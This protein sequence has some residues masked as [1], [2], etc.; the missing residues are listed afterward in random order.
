[1]S[2]TFKRGIR[3]RRLA[4]ESLEDRRLLVTVVNLDLGRGA[5]PLHI[6]SSYDDS[7]PLPL[8]VSLHGYSQSGS[9]IANYLNLSEQIEDN[10]FLYLVPQGNVDPGGQYFWN[11]TDA[12]CN[13][14]GSNVA[15]STYLR[16][17]VE[18]VSRTYAVDDRSIHFMG[19]SNGGFMTHRMALE[20]ADMV[21][22]IISLS[23]V[24]YLDT[25]VF[26]PSEPVH[27]LHVHGTADSVIRYA[28]GCIGSNCY[29]SAEQ[30]VLDWTAYNGL[31]STREQVGGPFDL[32]VDVNG[33]EATKY[34]YDQGNQAGVTVELWTL[35]G[36]AHVPT[37][38]ASA[39][40]PSQNRMAPRAVEWLLAH[41]KPDIA[42]PVVTGT[43][44][45]SQQVDPSNLPKGPQPTSWESQRSSIRS[46]S[47][48]FDEPVS[49]D[50][51]DLRLTNLGINAPMVADQPVVLSP[52]HLSLNSP[53]TVA[54]LSFAANELADGVYRIEVLS[55]A[56][57]IAGNP[58]D[59]DRNGTGGDSYLLRGNIAN[60]F[61]Q[62]EADWNGDDGISVFDFT[63]FSSWF[64]GST[65]AEPFAPP[66]VDLN[67]DDGVSVFDFTGFSDNFGVGVVYQQALVAASPATAVRLD[68]RDGRRFDQVELN[69]I[70]ERVIEFSRIVRSNNSTLEFD[71]KEG[72]DL[73]ME[74]EH[75]LDEI[76]KDFVQRTS[77][78]NVFSPHA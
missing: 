29:P 49:I 69:R 68:N 16:D 6:P 66:Y 44:I 55:T 46:I 20:H 9:S 60:K 10:R 45:N 34:V 40:A 52:V 31:N 17:L 78:L 63:T 18:E 38:R 51:D 7:E 64:G 8:I 72:D 62:L 30:A 19:L 11:A 27:V 4:V 47:I 61:Y 15:D 28:G 2:K 77:F 73:G 67:N 21:A 37:Y 22:S 3:R 23:G 33:A 42:P 43:S 14:Y 58:L 56:T 25:N 59:G 39:E 32:D 12:C 65:I 50:V 13:F 35:T 5:V 41:R 71:N 76:A 74:L 26:Q 54:T 24:P 53:R 70:D 48:T 36:S 1:L 75:L 57:D